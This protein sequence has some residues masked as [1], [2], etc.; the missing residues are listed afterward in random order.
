LGV[1][2]GY[3]KRIYARY[4]SLSDAESGRSQVDR[5]RKWERAYKTYLAGWLPSDKAARI[6]DVGCGDGKLLSY[7][8]DSGY[9]DVEGVDISREQVDLARRITED[10]SEQD[11]LSLLERSEGGYD[12]I[13]G[14]DFLEHLDKDEACRFLEACRHALRPTG[15]LILQTPN[16]DSPWGMSYRYGDLTHET[17][18]NP[19]S[20]AQLLRTYQFADISCR[21][22]GPVVH[23]FLSF[24][25]LVLW[26]ILRQFLAL[27]NIVET[28]D[29]RSGIYTR[30]FLASGKRG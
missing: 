21:E 13:T 18:Y 16:A 25:R 11:V 3:R 26:S 23:G 8:I 1:G 24:C 2:K 10:V 27:W 22:A 15:R 12:L 30:V 5:A 7:L 14:I 29:R 19:S 17:C 20:L 28:G 4:V 6:L 9:R